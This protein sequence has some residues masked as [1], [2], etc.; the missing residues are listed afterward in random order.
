[1]IS[2]IRRTWARCRGVAGEDSPFRSRLVKVLA[3]GYGLCK[4][5][6]VDTEHGYG[7][8]WVNFEE[9][10]L[11]LVSGH[12]IDGLCIVGDLFP[13]KDVADA[14]RTV[15][16]KEI[17]EN[18]FVAFRWFH[19]VRTMFTENVIWMIKE[20]YLINVATSLCNKHHETLLH[21]KIVRRGRYGI[22]FAVCID[23]CLPVHVAA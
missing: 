11:V 9:S 13:V 6:A 12:E 1:M 8:V 5:S 2:T 18:N 21:Q 19:L 17:I 7:T 22:L 15:A 3:N 10:G 20:I 4:K 14:P 16:S 23:A